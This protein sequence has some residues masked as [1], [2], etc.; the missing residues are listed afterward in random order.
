M[1]QRIVIKAFEE[2]TNVELYEILRLR[3]E[4]FVVEQ[5][6]IY[7]DIDGKDLSCHHVM[8]YIGNMLAAYSRVVPAGLSYTEISLGRVLV[9]PDFRGQGLGK[10]IVQETIEACYAILGK[11]DIKIGAQYHL[12][13]MYQSLGFEPEGQPYDEDGIEHIDMLKR[14]AK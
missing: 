6:C 8:L 4:V 11:A 1:E 12:L 9:N 2:L 13:A 7:Q 10:L 5:T 14:Y 3:S